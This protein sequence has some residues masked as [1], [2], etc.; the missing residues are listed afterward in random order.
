MCVHHHTLRLV[1]VAHEFS[2][3]QVRCPDPQASAPSDCL[4]WFLGSADVVCGRG[5]LP[6]VIVVWF[7]A[8]LPAVS[9]D[10]LDRLNTHVWGLEPIK[11]LVLLSSLGLVYQGADRV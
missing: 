4:F 11:V 8:P 6:S 3:G 7:S 2:H 5:D 1:D 9:E 10:R